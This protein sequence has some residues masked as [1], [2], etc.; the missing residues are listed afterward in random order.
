[1]NVST[2]NQKAIDGMPSTYI[3]EDGLE[4][5]AGYIEENRG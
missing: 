2:Q 4:Y 3:E 1:M 5:I